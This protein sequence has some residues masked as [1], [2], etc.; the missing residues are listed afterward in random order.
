MIDLDELSNFIKS[1]NFNYS[2]VHHSFN[3]EV[4]YKYL[5]EFQ[6]NEEASSIDPIFILSLLIKV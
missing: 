4:F 6:V 2:K 1:K 5:S 3:P